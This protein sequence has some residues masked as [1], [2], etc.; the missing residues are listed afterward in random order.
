MFYRFFLE[1]DWQVD[2]GGEH[3]SNGAGGENEVSWNR[4]Y[5]DVRRNF[6][7]GFVRF[8]PWARVG[9]VRYNPDITDFLGYAQAEIGWWPTEN[10]EV[11]L[12]VS[13]LFSNSV[14]HNYYG[15]SWNVP[16]YQS[17]RGYIKAETGY[18]LTISNYNFDESAVGVG[19]AFSF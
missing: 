7:W 18:G 12:L 15:I 4:I 6:D 10:Q 9:N 5:V 1:E 19:A 13:N 8:K 14:T 3:A 17:L 16:I 2:V 11:K